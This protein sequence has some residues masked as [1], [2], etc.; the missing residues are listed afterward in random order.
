MEKTPTAS[1]A[2]AT[3]RDAHNTT[4]S[5]IAGVELP[6][7]STKKQLAAVLGVSPKHIENLTTRGLL[8][9][10][11]L[12]RCVRYRRDAVMRALTEMEGNPI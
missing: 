1:P 12:G 9:P 2:T 11:R 3:N 4:S 7:V 8:K 10:V 6:L 5:Q